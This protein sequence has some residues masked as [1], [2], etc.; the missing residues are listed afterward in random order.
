MR[1][2]TYTAFVTLGEA[3]K[4]P[5][6]SIDFGTRSDRQSTNVRQLAIQAGT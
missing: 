1:R 4:A 5:G 3:M 6:K 2:I